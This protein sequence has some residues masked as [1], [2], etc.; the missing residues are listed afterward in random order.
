MSGPHISIP[1]PYGGSTTFGST[2][3]DRRRS[4]MGMPRFFKRYATTL[5]TYNSRNIHGH[6]QADRQHHHGRLFKFPQMDFEMAIWEMTHL[7]YQPKKVFKSIY[8]HK[9]NTPRNIPTT[10]TPPNTPYPQKQK[11]HGTVP[12]P[13]SPTSSPSSSS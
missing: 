10:T 3:P 7:L 8:Y 6:M 12:T 13:P 4:E 11:T 9:R 1:R 5:N 2:A